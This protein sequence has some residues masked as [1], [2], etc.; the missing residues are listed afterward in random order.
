MLPPDGRELPEELVQRGSRLQI[1]EQRLDGHPRTDEHR[2]TAQDLGVAVHDWR[3]AQHDQAVQRRS[4][5]SRMA[6]CCPL[7]G[8][9]PV[10]GGMLA[11]IMRRS[12]VVAR[13]A[14]H[15]QEM[16]NRCAVRSLALFG[17]VAR[18]EARADSDVDVLVEFDGPTTFDRHMGM[19]VFLEDLLGCRVDVVTPKGLRPG[20]RQAI[21]QDLV[22]VA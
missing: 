14:A 4:P 17:S 13:L 9:E 2:R 1:V 12:D 19:L 15:R 22:R 20:R 3:V 11:P 6:V 5:Q 16:A 8:T 18:D 21:E 7:A 10:G